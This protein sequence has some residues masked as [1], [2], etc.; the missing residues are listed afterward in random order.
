M[1]GQFY[2]GADPVRVTTLLGSCIAITVWHPVRK[3]GGI[4]HYLVPSSKGRT[5]ERPPGM[6]AEGAVELFK[7]E[8]SKARTQPGEYVVKIFGGGNMFSVFARSAGGNPKLSDGGM[9]IS[10][11]NI[12]AARELLPASGFK[13]AAEDVGGRSARKIRF[14]LDNGDTW[15]QRGAD[16]AKST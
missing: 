12:A 3:I 5:R 2:F 13:I 11:E 9:R 10:D 16:P 4:C 6:D 14:H 15:V 8:V 7:Q 1:T